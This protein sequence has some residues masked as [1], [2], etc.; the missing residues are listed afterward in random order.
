VSLIAT[1]ICCLM[2]FLEGIGLGDSCFVLF[3][4]G[5]C[6]IFFIQGRSIRLRW[7]LLMR[8][9]VLLFIWFCLIFCFDAFL[10]VH[11]KRVLRFTRLSENNCCTFSI[12]SWLKVRCIR[13]HIFHLLLAVVLTG[14]LPIL[15]SCFSDEDQSECC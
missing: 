12:R 6:Q 11:L 7:C 4:C 2:L 9:F 10:S 1:L 3:V 8:R 5:R 15:I 13:C 14:Q